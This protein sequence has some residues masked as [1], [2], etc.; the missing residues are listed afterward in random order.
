LPFFFSGSA[1]WR[2][3]CALRIADMA[4]LLRR[5]AKRAGT[6]LHL[7]TRRTR[8]QD[9]TWDVTSTLVLVRMGNARRK[10]KLRHW[11]LRI[12]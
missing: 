4:V 6:V 2:E 11:V 7:M 12:D 9:D 8:A 10:L 3:F 5:A 1:V